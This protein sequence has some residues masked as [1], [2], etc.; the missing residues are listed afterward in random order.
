M[1]MK[2]Y[3][4][5]QLLINK[6]LIITCSI[7]VVI[8]FTSANVYAYVDC[9]PDRKAVTY[10]VDMLNFD[11]KNSKDK[12]IFDPAVLHICQ[13]DTIVWKDKDPGHNSASWHS[14]KGAK[15]WFGELDENISITF[16]VEG[17]Y[18]YRCYPH[19][20]FATMIGIIVVNKPS[21][22]KIIEDKLKMLE[23]EFVL[24]PKRTKKYLD[25]IRYEVDAEPSSLK[26]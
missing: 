12:M 15:S 14:P 13:G 17:T 20:M 9:K 21:Q 23:E 1:V 16:K 10:Y 4:N 7:F 19:T 3:L 22:K 11:R 26:K 2:G 5:L 6:M 25:L 8:F 18:I 24:N